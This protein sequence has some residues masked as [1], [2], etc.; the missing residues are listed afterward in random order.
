M[1]QTL[2]SSSQLVARCRSKR[3]IECCGNKENKCA[4]GAQTCEPSINYTTRHKALVRL[5]EGHDNPENLSTVGG[6]LPVRGVNEVFR[7]RNCSFYV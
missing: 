2:E 1:E 3:G 4:W 7:T 6:I 5:P